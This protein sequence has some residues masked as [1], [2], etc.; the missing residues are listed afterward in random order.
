MKGLVCVV[1]VTRP[2]LAFVL[3]FLSRKK[4]TSVDHHPGRDQHD[5]LPNVAG[6]RGPLGRLWHCCHRG[7][8]RHL[9]GGPTKRGWDG[10]R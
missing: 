8:A 3:R 5:D 9:T 2:E 10:H 7:A 1:A 6:D 4:R